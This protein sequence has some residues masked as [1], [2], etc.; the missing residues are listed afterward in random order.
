MDELRLSLIAI[1]VVIVGGVYVVGK[2][3]ERSRSVRVATSRAEPVKE[4]TPVA[5]RASEHDFKMEIEDGEE[6]QIQ[7]RVSP[8]RADSLHV[9]STRGR[10]E[11]A[12][13]V[14]APKPA[15]VAIKTQSPFVVARVPKAE[16]PQLRP[17]PSEPDLIVSLTLMAR[18]QQKF[19]GSEL[20]KVLQAAGLELAEF[21]IYHFRDADAE[22]DAR[23][24]FSVANIVKPGTF[25][26]KKLHDLTTSGLAMFMQIPGPMTASEAFDA[27]LEKAQ[28]IAL[29]LQGIVGDEQRTPLNP[30]R[31]RSLR[32]RTLNYDFSN[33]VQGSAGDVP[34]HRPH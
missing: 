10:D 31:M 7:P 9:S 12:R 11:P 14:P 30:Q 18:D 19:N 16:Q 34:T 1:G 13:R 15:I 23:A 5:A 33:A 4:A 32:E 24:V 25:D 2:M 20:H 28:F 21:D 27:M 8:P 3:V 6:L 17:T 26:V 29:H 22:G